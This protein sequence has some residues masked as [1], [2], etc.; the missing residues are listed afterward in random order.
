MERET[1]QGS[2]EGKPNENNKGRFFPGR[3]IIPLV[4]GRPVADSIPL[5][6]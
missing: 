5:A 3:R 2:R 4:V 6:G 1:R